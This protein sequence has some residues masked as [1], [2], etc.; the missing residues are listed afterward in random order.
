MKSAYKVWTHPLCAALCLLSAPAWAQSEPKPAIPPLTTEAAAAMLD[1][2]LTLEQRKDGD[3]DGD[4]E[5]DT[6]IVGRSDDRRVLMALL[7]YRSEVDL[8]H[9]PVGTL[10]LD[11]YPLGGASIS[12]RKGVLVIED[13][14][15]GTTATQTTYR[16]RYEP[17]TQR[18]RLIGLDAQNYSRTNSHGT[19]KLSWN[20]LTGDRVIERGEPNVSGKGDEAIVYAPAKRDK[21]ASKPLYM[22]TTPNPDELLN[23]L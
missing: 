9:Q 3:F 5:T 4:G 17:K 7:A 10:E 8:G 22:E 12:M 11:A 2:G 21:R 14:T 13:L 16:Y 18:M 19:L 23:T 6:V 1:G 20:L 15:G